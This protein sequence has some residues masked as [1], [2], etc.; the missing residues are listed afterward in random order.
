MGDGVLVF[1]FLLTV[2]FF[3]GTGNASDNQFWSLIFC[4]GK[5]GFP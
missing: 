5:T 3:S 2:D 4:E 1:L